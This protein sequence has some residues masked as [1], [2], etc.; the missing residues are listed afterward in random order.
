MKVIY[1]SGPYRGD[2]TPDQIF[3]NI[4]RARAAAKKVW[5]DGNAAI[6]PHMNTAFMDGAADD[7]VWLKGDMAILCRCDEMYV[8]PGWED[9]AGTKQEIV[10]ASC[11]KL[12]I[13]Y[14]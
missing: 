4:M 10:T 1:I 12:P 5:Q 14:L 8:L 7:S 9:S 3:E 6:C 13:T 2:G 11:L